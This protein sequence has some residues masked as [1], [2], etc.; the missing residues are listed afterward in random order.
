MQTIFYKGQY[1]NVNFDRCACYVV[2]FDGND[3][4]TKHFKTFLGAKRG[5]TKFNKELGV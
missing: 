1:I 4:T 2:F 5:I 3:Y